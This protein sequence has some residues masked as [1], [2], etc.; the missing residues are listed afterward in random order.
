MEDIIHL[1]T[2]LDPDVIA[3]SE[4]NLHSSNEPHEVNIPGYNLFTTA[5]YNAGGVS[6]LVVLAKKE[7]NCHLLEDK[8]E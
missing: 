1:A 4:A 6:R 7:L 2:D 5:D 3:I 8:L